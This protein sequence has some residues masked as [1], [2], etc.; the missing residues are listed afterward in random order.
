MK[1]TVLC[2]ALV[3]FL[4]LPVVSVFASGAGEPADGEIVLT[5]PTFWVGQ[6]SKSG[7]IATLVQ[8]FNA[9]YEGEIRVLIEPSP[10]TAELGDE[11][12][13]ARVVETLKG[14]LGLRV[15]VSVV[16]YGSL[17]RTEGK[18]DRLADRRP[19][20]HEGV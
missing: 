12:R 13:A 11:E 2:I 14:A 7:P 8:Q 20:L 19:K 18:A 15:D 5:F 6:D 16:P 4:A 1:R 10:D 17:P 3:A 9:E